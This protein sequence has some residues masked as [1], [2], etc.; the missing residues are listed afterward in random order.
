MEQANHILTAVVRKARH[1]DGAA[2][3]WLYEQFS[4]AMFN[5]C[6][7]M[8]GNR[9]D[10]ED[11][12]QEAFIQAFKNLHQLKE[13]VHFGGWLKRI[14]VNACIQHSKKSFYWSEW[15]EQWHDVAEDT[16][17]AWW[18]TVDLQLVHKAIKNLP[19]GCRQVFTLF[20]LEDFSH[21]QIAE[22]LGISEST[23]KSQYHRAK[24]LLRERITQEMQ[25]HG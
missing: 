11:L 1:G 16:Q 12:L 9:S 7:R 20:V 4:T 14:V 23:S 25:T 21:K 2:Q 13:E 17:V 22:N 15:D 10:A 18:K 3:A 19:D 8:T 5:T 24:Q 6:I